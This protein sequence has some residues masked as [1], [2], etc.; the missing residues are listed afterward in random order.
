M[1]AG[2]K[3]KMKRVLKR[4]QESKMIASDRGEFPCPQYVS[5][6]PEIKEEFKF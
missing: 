1:G 2:R 3:F 5:N 4:L 6:Y